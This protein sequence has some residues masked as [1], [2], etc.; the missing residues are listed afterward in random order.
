MPSVCVDFGTATEFVGS[1]P[2]LRRHES[3]HRRHRVRRSIVDDLIWLDSRQHVRVCIRLLRAAL[4]VGRAPRSQGLAYVDARMR[5][6]LGA[7]RRLRQ[8]GIE[9]P[10]RDRP[11]AEISSCSSGCATASSLTDHGATPKIACNTRTATTGSVDVPHPSWAPWR[12]G[13]EL[14]IYPTYDWAHGQS[15]A[16]EGVTT[17]LHA[18]VRQPSCPVHWYPH[19]PNHCRVISPAR[20]SSPVVAHP[21][22][23]LERR[24]ARWGR[25]S[26]RCLGRPAHAH[27]AWCAATWLP[28]GSNTGVLRYTGV[29]RP[30]AGTRSSVL[31]SFIRPHSTRPRNVEWRCCVR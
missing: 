22:H 14:V 10:Y 7:A 26:G 11:V 15:D 8:P 25:R 18:R 24:L 20:P 16:I 30:T 6:H 2:A 4:P 23:H 28:A 29:T 5:D 1:Q 13:D 12:T 21:H 27:A 17:R 19:P 3:R 9:S 31:E